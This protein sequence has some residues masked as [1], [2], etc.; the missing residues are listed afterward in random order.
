VKVLYFDCLS[1]ISGDMTLGALLDLGIEEQLF[2][3]ELA[4]LSLAGYDL[5]IRKK[6]KNGI[7]GTDIDVVLTDEENQRE[8]NL[9][10]IELLINKSGIAQRA[11]DFT[12]KVFRE[13]A[14]A[15]A[16]VHHQKISEVH[17]HEV[18]AIDSI[19]DIAGTAIC[20]DLLG[21]DMVYASKLYD[22]HGFIKCRHGIIPV[23]VPAVMEL[24]SE[25]GIP[26]VQ[27]DIDTE[28]ITPTGMGII[29]CL[30]SGFGTMPQI[31]VC[32]VG[33]GMGKREYD[34]FGALRVIM[35]T[36]QEENITT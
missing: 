32:K 11:K 21:A 34:G 22:G 7:Y 30:S 31:S 27:T 10:D 4:K 13:I 14:A 17:F 35:G 1:G 6:E 5:V 25:S 19:V 29:K 33:Y 24:L 18:G 20:L 26:L 16:K 36:V 12:K 15:E 23:P 2:R 8:R 28:L 3:Q 9:Q